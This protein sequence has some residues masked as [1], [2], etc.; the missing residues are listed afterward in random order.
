M[1][2]VQ[3][4]LSCNKTKYWKIVYSDASSR[5]RCR[6][7]RLV[8]LAAARVDFPAEGQR[9]TCPW[10]SLSPCK[11]SG[12]DNAQNLFTGKDWTGGPKDKF[13]SVLNLIVIIIFPRD[14]SLFLGASIST[15]HREN[16]PG[17]GYFIA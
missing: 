12:L 15:S 6:G 13:N 14:K 11:Q 9:D 17:A 7:P 10:V 4:S 16:A 5:F 1:R 3:P 8:T 2:V